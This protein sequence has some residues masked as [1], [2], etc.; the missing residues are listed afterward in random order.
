MAQPINFCINLLYISFLPTAT[1]T[2]K[3]LCIY[4]QYHGAARL[5][6]GQNPE[7]VSSTSTP[8]TATST[9]ITTSSSQISVD[10]SSSGVEHESTPPIEITNNGERRSGNMNGAK[11]P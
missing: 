1:T 7:I 6:F 10:N 2:K 5:A 4:Q 9:A 11:V 3:N 8:N